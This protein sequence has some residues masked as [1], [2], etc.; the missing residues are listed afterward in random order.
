MRAEASASARTRRNRLAQLP[1][2]RPLLLMSNIHVHSPKLGRDLHR[3]IAEALAN[4]AVTA[5]F[6]AHYQ[7]IVR[8]EDGVTV[9][10]EALARWIHPVHGA[11]HPATFVGVAESMDLMH[12]ID[13]FV[14]DRA[15]ADADDVARAC[16]GPVDI[17][18]N[19]SAGRLE[20]SRFERALMRTLQARC[21]APERLVLEI[22]ETAQI[23]DLRAAVDAAR[24]IRAMGVRIALDDFGAGFNWLGR[25]HSLPVDIVKLDGVMTVMEAGSGRPRAICQAMLELCGK[26]QLIVIAEGIETQAQAEGLSRLGCR[27]G[28]GYLYGCAQ[29][30][31]RLSDVCALSESIPAIAV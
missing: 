8:L 3:S 30:V 15:C 28:Q 21:L 22:T 29:P 23:T 4:D 14:L 18:V 16:G 10:V 12:V 7:P 13:D 5:E 1:Q 24:R 9:A 2:L 17:H 6:E 27:L 26:L 19:V 31:D 25:L 20:Q 11:I